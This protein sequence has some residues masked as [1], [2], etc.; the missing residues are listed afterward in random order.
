MRVPVSTAEGQNFWLAHPELVKEVDFIAVQILPYWQQQ[1]LDA[2]LQFTNAI[3]DQLAAAYPEMK[4]K[5]LISEVGWPSSGHIRGPAEASRTNEAVFIRRWLNF[6]EP[7]K[8]DY[9]VMEAF[10]QT[11][12]T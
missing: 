6:A 11:W 7:R 3:L 9:F 10:D 5:I 4:G 2:T 12:K 8:L 1:P